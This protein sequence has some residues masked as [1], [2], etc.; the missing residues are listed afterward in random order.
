MRT[1]NRGQWIGQTP[2]TSELE[3]HPW[4]PLPSAGQGARSHVASNLRQFPR[5]REQRRDDH[6]DDFP[7]ALDATSCIVGGTIAMVQRKPKPYGDNILSGVNARK[8]ANPPD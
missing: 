1:V 4:D 7:E 6:T 3:K 8:P 5:R 2:G